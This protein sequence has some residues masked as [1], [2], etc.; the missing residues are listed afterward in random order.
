[1][2]FTKGKFSS[3]PDLILMDGGLGQ[4]SIAEKVLG[5]LG[6]N[7]PVC[8]MVK[9]D[10]H[11]TRGLIYSGEE[12]LIYKDSGIFKLVAKIQDEAHRVAIEYHRSLRSKGSVMS[13]LDGISGIGK[14]RRLALINHFTGI[15]D[16]KRASVEELKKVKGMNEKSAVAVYEYF[17][18]EKN[19]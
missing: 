5:G 8:G 9:D 16:I 10:K 15:D 18:N 19:E 6:L 12:V 2:E 3:L 14:T 17:K 11:R 1:V 4:V 13:I 7:I